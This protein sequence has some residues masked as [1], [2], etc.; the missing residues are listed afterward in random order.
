[1]I[2]LQKGVQSMAIGTSFVLDWFAQG[3][4]NSTLITSFSPDLG[5]FTAYNEKY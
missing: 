4:H 2:T 1:M 5:N 3:I